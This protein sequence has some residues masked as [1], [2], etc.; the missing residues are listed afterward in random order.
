MHK[1]EI[2]KTYHVRSICDWDC[3]FSFEVVK[4]TAQTV[5]LRDCSG[6]VRARRVREFD[7]SEACDPHG[8]YSMSPILTAQPERHAPKAA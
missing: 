2:G 4:R 3:V 5:W 6:K 7:G 1:F 8:R